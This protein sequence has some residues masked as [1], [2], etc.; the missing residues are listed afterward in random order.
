MTNYRLLTDL[1]CFF[2]SLLIGFL[3]HFRTSLT[4]TVL[5]MQLFNGNNFNFILTNDCT[6]IAIIGVA[7]L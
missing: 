6:D 1:S 3:H 7:L 2:L 5:L 4:L